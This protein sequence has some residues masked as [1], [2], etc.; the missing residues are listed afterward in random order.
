[1]KSNK[2]YPTIKAIR[3]FSLTYRKGRV[4]RSESLLLHFRQREDQG[5]PRVGYTV[6]RKVKSAV[7]RN[8]LK[9]LMRE[10]MRL[11]NEKIKAGLDIILVAKKKTTPPDFH[12]LHQELHDMIGRAG[13]AE[14]DSS[15]EQSQRE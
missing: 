2:P 5:L 14:K 12:S 8:R 15:S 7:E 11:Q 9:R 10:A 13:L 3:D 4:I 6:S 1:M